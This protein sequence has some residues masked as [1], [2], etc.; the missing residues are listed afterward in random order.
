MKE[1]NCDNGELYGAY[2]YDE[3]IR[4]RDNKNCGLILNKDQEEIVTRFS[5]LFKLD[6]LDILKQNYGDLFDQEY[7]KNKIPLL[8]SDKQNIPLVYKGNN[9]LF[10]FDPLT[11]KKY[12]EKQEPTM[13]LRRNVKDKKKVV[14]QKEI[15]QPII[16]EDN[17]NNKKN[18]NK[19]TNN[20]FYLYVIGIVVV[21]AIILLIYF[22]IFK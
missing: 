11:L 16:I 20:Q 18:T 10:Y 13:Y 7:N 14:E 19:K 22:M 4:L 3:M 12:F 5:D 17:T 6:E 15:E 2:K 1:V 21:I 8:V 9:N